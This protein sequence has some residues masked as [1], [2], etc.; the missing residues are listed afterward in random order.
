M[1]SDHDDLYLY[2]SPRAIANVRLVQLDEEKLISNLE[3]L[4]TPM[5]LLPILTSSVDVDTATETSLPPL[6]T[7]SI[8]SSSATRNGDDS[9]SVSSVSLEEDSW[10]SPAIPTTQKRSIFG[11]YWTK[12]GGRPKTSYHTARSSGLEDLKTDASV[13]DDSYEH[14]LEKSEA[15]SHRR[16]SDTSVSSGGVR[17]RSLWNNR[18]VAQSEPALTQ[19]V[20]APLRKTRSSS[21][22]GPRRS[23]LRKGRY[24]GGGGADTVER[25]S[26]EVTSV[27][28]SKD[29]Q[30]KFLKK[31]VTENFAFRGWSAYF[32]Q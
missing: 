19:C 18:Y 22:V 12:K 27:S 8:C 28:F 2:A 29:V 7:L 26:S 4:R 20:E 21:A 13:E 6:K 15:A 16:S 14:L 3:C 1:A 5:S 32:M 10:D 31:P 24:S 9:S 17:R 30:V 23:C 11:P 25:R